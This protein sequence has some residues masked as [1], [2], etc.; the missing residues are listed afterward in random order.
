MKTVVCFG[1]ALI[2][3]LNTGKHEDGK[4]QLNQFTQFP[5]GAPANA[6]VAVAKLGG[7]SKFMGQVGNDLFGDFLIESLEGYDVDTS[8]T[9]QHA[10]APTALAYVFLDKFGERSFD[11][12][13]DNTAD[14]LFSTKQIRSNTFRANSILH[15]CSNTLTEEDIGNVTHHIVRLASQCNS[16]VSFDVNLRH[17]LWKGKKVERETVNE[18]V[19][20][21][22]LVK[23]SK[24]EL[25]FLSGGEIQSYLSSCF[26]KQTKLVLVTDGSYP[27]SIVSSKQSIKVQA[28]SVEVVD[29]TGGGDGFIGAVLFGLSQQKAPHEAL[30]DLKMMKKIVEFASYCGAHT[31]SKSGAFPALPTFNDVKK[32]WRFT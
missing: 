7:K 11:F 25:E 32:Y 27:I 6:A 24:E 20:N 10:S 22:H 14:L 4:L 21:S 26:S 12:R 23:F 31:V 3:F 2:D 19:A 29:T 1:E 15:F 5:G 17:L 30:S 28:P 18:L 16:L 13:R 8:L 9:Y